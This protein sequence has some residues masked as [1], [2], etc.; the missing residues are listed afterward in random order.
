MAANRADPELMLPE[1]RYYEVSEWKCL[2]EIKAFLSSGHSG[3]LS[4]VDSKKI[5]SIEQVMISY[6]RALRLMQ[7]SDKIKRPESAF[8]MLLSGQ[9]QISRAQE[10]VG[11][12]SSTNSVLIVYDEERDYISCINYCGSSMVPVEQIPIPYSVRESDDTVFSRM[13]RVELSF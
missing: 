9:N 10:A 12:T 4:I 1:I 5:F 3:F 7:T 13:A 2:A 6:E 11:I 8:L